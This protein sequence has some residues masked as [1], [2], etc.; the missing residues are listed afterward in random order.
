MRSTHVMCRQSRKG[1]STILGTLIFI[2]ILF[3][4][5]IPMMLVMRQADT[6]YEKEV[7]ELK[8]KDDEKDRE[9]VIVYAYPKGSTSNMV[10][11]KVESSCEV[12]VKI[13]R[14][15]INN[16]FQSQSVNVKSMGEA[17]L[18]PF[19]VP[20]APGENSTF[21]FRVVSERGNVYVPTSGGVLKYSNGEWESQVLSINVVV[22]CEAFLGLAR[23]RVTVT[24]ETTYNEIKDTGGYVAGTQFFVFDVTECGTGS[25]H[26]KIEAR[27]IF[28]SWRIIHEEDV[29]IEYPEGP[30]DVWVRYS[31]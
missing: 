9:D 27:P 25:F 16:T 22:D 5:V 1:V 30:P 14:V 8:Q 21:S 26:V 3:T 4:S 10:E 24:N 23:Y 19:T 7:L 6:I 11:L 20:V 13:V 12:A 29:E 18:G 31:E 15:W 2:G 17:F 28:Q